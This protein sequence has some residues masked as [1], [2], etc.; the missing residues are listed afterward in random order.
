MNQL[1]QPDF[2]V[3]K[4]EL[5]ILNEINCEKC[6]AKISLIK[7]DELD[8]LKR[9]A[10]EIDTTNFCS[11]LLLN[12]DESDVSC[13]IDIHYTNNSGSEQNLCYKLKFKLLIKF[14]QVVHI[15]LIN[16]EDLE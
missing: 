8:V 7:Q 3:L 4:F 14:M 13:M 15:S 2:L 11:D 16:I 12:S 6:K 10:L 9:Y 1:V 5:N